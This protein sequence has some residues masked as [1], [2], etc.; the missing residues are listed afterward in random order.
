MEIFA[1]GK[2]KKRGNNGPYSPNK[3][4]FQNLRILSIKFKVVPEEVLNY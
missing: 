4:L 3:K 2:R 1:G